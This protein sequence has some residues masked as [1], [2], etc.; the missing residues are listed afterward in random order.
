[1]MENVHVINFV[2]KWLLQNMERIM[3]MFAN[4]VS[5][6]VGVVQEIVNAGQII[7]RVARQLMLWWGI[8]LKMESASNA[9]N[10]PKVKVG[11]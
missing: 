6:M 4:H 7:A 5:H 8:L 10:H 1:M 11:A 2:L 3:F 9:A